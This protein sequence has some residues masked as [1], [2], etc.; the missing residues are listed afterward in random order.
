M[1]DQKT[2]VWDLLGCSF[3]FVAGSVKFAVGIVVV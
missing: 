3:V 2:G 1:K